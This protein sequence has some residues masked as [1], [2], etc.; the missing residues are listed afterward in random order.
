M[1]A[2]GA[3]AEF[4]A[5][6]TTVTLTGTGI[7]AAEVTG[8]DAILSLDHQA[9]FAALGEVGAPPPI[10][11]FGISS[12]DQVR[13]ALDSGAAGVISGSA[14]VGRV[15]EGVDSVRAFVSSMKAATRPGF[16]K[17]DAMR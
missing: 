11:G 7:S 8:A 17:P 9:L 16:C 15:A 2:Q 13:Q 12:P 4:P 10:L 5:M 1:N 3:R 6:S 14:I